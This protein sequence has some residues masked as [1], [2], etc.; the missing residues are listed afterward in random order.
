MFWSTYCG[1]GEEGFSTQTPV[2]L[3]SEIVPNGITTVVGALGVDTTMKTI[4]GRLA[5]V[6]ALEEEGLSVYCWSGGYNVPPTTVTGSIRNDMLFI[7]AVIGAGEIAIADHRSVDPSAP[8]LARLVLDTHVG[9]I[10]SRKAGVTHFHTGGYDQRLRRVRDLLDGDHP[11]TP[12]M[13]CPTHIERTEALMDEAI[14]LA[15]RGSHCDIDTVEG[16]LARWVAY[17]FDH[18]GDPERLTVSSD[19]GASAGQKR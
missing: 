6:E 5:R 11:V 7:E 16:D 2:V 10:L 9:G 18:G 12:E 1:S 8:E 17:W 14:A 15:T 4:A 19:T 3:L 13:L